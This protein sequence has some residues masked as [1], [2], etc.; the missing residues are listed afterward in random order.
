MF[1]DIEPGFLVFSDDESEDD[2]FLGHKL[3]KSNGTGIASDVNQ[4]KSNKMI[5][6]PIEELDENDENGGDVRSSF[7]TSA[8]SVQLDNLLNRM[9]FDSMNNVDFPYELE[10][11]SMM[12][13]LRGY[14]LLN[15]QVEYS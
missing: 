11:L 12:E 8:F 1:G 9:L 3:T 2:S 10:G 5:G 6:V 4:I 13:N 14:V 15:A 7:K